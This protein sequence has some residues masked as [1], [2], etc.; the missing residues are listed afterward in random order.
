MSLNEDNYECYNYTYAFDWPT[1]TESGVLDIQEKTIVAIFPEKLC[2]RSV[3][4]VPV[5]NINLFLNQKLVFSYDWLPIYTIFDIARVKSIFSQLFWA[6]SQKA[7]ITNTYLDSYNYGKI[8]DS[9]SINIKGCGYYLY[10]YQDSKNTSLQITFDTISDAKEQNTKKV[11]LKIFIGKN[12]VFCTK[13]DLESLLNDNDFY[14]VTQ[15]ILLKL[16]Q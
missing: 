16:W 2:N 14:Y 15:F 10:C 5:Q 6:F 7:K 1:V 13:R 3:E 12:L 11:D 8:Y 4:P 9:E